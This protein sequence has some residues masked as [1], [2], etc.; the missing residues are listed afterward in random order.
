M[1]GLA[2]A[3][4]TH[5]PNVCMRGW[6]D[7]HDTPDLVSMTWSTIIIEQHPEVEL[8]VPPCIPEK[9]DTTLPIMA[10]WLGRRIV[11]AILAST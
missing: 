3:F 2:I 11:M 10:V 9:P 7:N 8:Q 5:M 6:G 4:G 1:C